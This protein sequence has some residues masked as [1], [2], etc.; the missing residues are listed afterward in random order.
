MIPQYPYLGGGPTAGDTRGG[1]ECISCVNFTNP[2][3]GRSI[4][5]SIIN[6]KGSFEVST[7]PMNSLRAGDNNALNSD[8]T[9]DVTID[10]TAASVCGY[11]V[12]S[13]TI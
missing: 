1:V 12:P 3:T 9:L 13:E 2:A 11:P 8:G 5:T 7:A 10:V 4:L 6:S